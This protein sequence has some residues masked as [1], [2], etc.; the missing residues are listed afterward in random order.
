MYSNEIVWRKN[1][2]RRSITTSDIGGSFSSNDLEWDKSDLTRHLLESDTLSS[3]DIH[4]MAEILRHRF[5]QFDMS[6]H[7]GEYSTLSHQS[8]SSDI[9]LPLFDMASSNENDFENCLLDRTL[10]DCDLPKLQIKYPLLSKHLSLMN[11][12]STQWTFLKPFR[13]ILTEEN[14]RQSMEITAESQVF[15][16]NRTENCSYFSK[17][18]MIGTYIAKLRDKCSSFICEIFQPTKI[19]FIT[20]E[21]IETY[22]IIEE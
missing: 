8:T 11:I 9:I 1:F 21:T 18:A 22:D 17:F 12:N 15:N 2:R 3:Y 10:S 14:Y 5:L 6:S 19:P 16:T 20:Q 13:M 7:V 4:E